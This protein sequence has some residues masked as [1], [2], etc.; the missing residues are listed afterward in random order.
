MHEC[1]KDERIKMLETKLLNRTAMFE[2]LKIVLTPKMIISIT[3]AVCVLVQTFANLIGG[4][5][6]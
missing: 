1:D 2:I 3:I 6:Q 5:L 4:A